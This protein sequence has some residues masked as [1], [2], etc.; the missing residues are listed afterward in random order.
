VYYNP[1]FESKKEILSW[2]WN[3]PARRSI[4][5]ALVASL[6]FLSCGGQSNQKTP[7]EIATEKGTG[8]ASACVE[9]QPSDDSFCHKSLNVIT[10]PANSHTTVGDGSATL[11]I[12]TT[13]EA[14]INHY[15][16][17]GPDKGTKFSSFLLAPNGTPQ[18]VGCQY[19]NGQTQGYDMFEYSVASA[20]FTT[21]PNCKETPAIAPAVNSCDTACQLPN[22]IDHTFDTNNPLEKA[23]LSQLNVV[24]TQLRNGNYAGTANLTGLFLAGSGCSNRTTTV[25][26]IS[27]GHGNVEDKGPSC[28]IRLPIQGVPSLSSVTVT[29]GPDVT[30][31]RSLAGG[32]AVLHFPPEQNQLAGITLEWF[33]NNNQSLGFEHVATIQVLPAVVKIR[34]DRHFCV[35]LEGQSIHSSGR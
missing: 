26:A 30:A 34:G 16:Q 24:R 11:S 23:A 1:V 20:C 28:A 32:A 25:E 15:D 6:F 33:D 13:I 3:V 21:D 35:W 8:D 2:R 12:W 4:R 27:P 7:C 31:T 19:D 9:L 22:C 10:V 18:T 14:N 5:C 17:P 29:I